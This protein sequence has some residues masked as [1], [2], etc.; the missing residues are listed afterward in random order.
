MGSDYCVIQVGKKYGI[1]RKERILQLM[2]PIRNG[3]RRGIHCKPIERENAATQMISP[4]AADRYLGSYYRGAF[5]HAI[6]ITCR[7]TLSISLLF[8]PVECSPNGTCKVPRRE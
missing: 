1:A 3:P 4:S 7:N 2:T 5:C 6:L 8:W